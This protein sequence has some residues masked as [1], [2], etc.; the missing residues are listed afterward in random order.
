MTC[1][2]CDRFGLKLS[3]VYTAEGFVELDAN[4]RKPDRMQGCLKSFQ[5]SGLVT[6][7]NVLVQLKAARTGTKGVCCAAHPLSVFALDS[8]PAPSLYGRAD[9]DRMRRV[10]ASVTKRS[11]TLS[12]LKCV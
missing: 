11:H 10:E 9:W 1:S 4:L 5:A 3:C 8:T 7:V 2:F 12:L 6:S